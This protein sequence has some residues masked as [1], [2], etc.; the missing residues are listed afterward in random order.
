MPLY[1]EQ[2]ENLLKALKS[3]LFKGLFDRLDFIKRLESDDDWSFVIK[4][5]ALIEAAVTEAAVA[6]TGEEKL[7]RVIERLPLVDG[8]T[9]KLTIGRDLGLLTKPQRRFVQKMAALRNQLAHR[10]E[11]VDF[12]FP[13]YLTSLECAA[14]RDWKESVAWFRD[15]REAP[16]FWLDAAAEQPRVAVTLAVFLL[17]GLLHVSAAEDGT[18][19]KINAAALQTA[20]EL[21]ASLLHH[22]NA[23]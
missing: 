3:H 23:G 11:S 8:D 1:R 17:V 14:L 20:E 5:Q 2:A 9:G 15:A 13:E 12:T 19:R 22:D 7:N 6:R 4:M 21:F 10:V 16:E 18:S